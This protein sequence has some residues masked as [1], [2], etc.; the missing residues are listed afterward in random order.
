VACVIVTFTK[1]DDGRTCSWTASRRGRR[2][3]PGTVMA[4]GAS[5]PHDLAQFVVEAK[6]GVRDGFWSCVE[7]GATFR[8]MGKRRTEPGRDI[9]RRHRTGLDEAEKVA[10]RELAAWW[11][12][13]PTPAGPELDA[14]LTLWRLVPRGGGLSLEWPSLR[15]VETPAA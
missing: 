8:S 6:L 12:K 2:P 11:A 15:P 3:V 14:A 5:I 1:S 4:A 7:Q 9:I 13:R 10:G